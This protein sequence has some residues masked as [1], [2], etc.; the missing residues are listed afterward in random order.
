M[1]KHNNIVPNHH[2]HKA[3]AGGSK[4]RGRQLKVRC[5]FKQAPKK[6]ARRLARA[7]L[8]AVCELTLV[9]ADANNVLTAAAAA[10]DHRLSRWAARRVEKRGR[11]GPRV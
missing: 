2:F 4:L 8:V 7:A 9:V 10:L 11:M 1:V 5:G 6:H 3:W